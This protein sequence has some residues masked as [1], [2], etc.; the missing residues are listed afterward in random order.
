MNKRF[1]LKFKRDR[2]AVLSLEY[3]RWMNFFVERFCKLRIYKPLPIGDELDFDLKYKNDGKYIEPI[4][5]D[6]WMGDLE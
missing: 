1:G 3:P 2:K 5:F 6:E 4:G